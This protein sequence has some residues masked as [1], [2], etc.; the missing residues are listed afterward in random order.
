MT[1]PRKGFIM[2]SQDALC[3][4]TTCLKKARGQRFSPHSWSLWVAPG[5]LEGG[6][7]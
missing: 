3:S 1:L 4:R 2:V 5:E 7:A 6:G